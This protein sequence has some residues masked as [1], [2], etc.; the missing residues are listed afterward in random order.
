MGRAADPLDSIAQVMKSAAT[1]RLLAMV[2]IAMAA[3]GTSRAETPVG[4]ARLRAFDPA[5]LETGDLIRYRDIERRDFRAQDPPVEAIG[6]HAELGAATCVFLA[7]D[8]DM[9]IRS[10]PRGLDLGF[11]QFR[12]R[13]QN[14]GFIAYMDR[15]CSWW[16]PSP[17]MLPAAYILQHEQIHFALFEI[18]ARRLN[19]RA[20]E[21]T[22]QLETVTASQ[23]EAVDAISEQLDAELLRAVNEVVARSND[24]DR[25]TSLTYRQ[26]K[27]SFWW[28]TVSVELERYRRSRR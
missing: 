3:T 10:S 13:V 12:T 28:N 11:D 9:Y 16:N 2:F 17:M 20:L 21:L 27:Q 4:Q 5:L 24:F 23:Q 7:T 19:S 14:L 6:L 15:E 1:I 26:D 22:A 18:A 8:P 25:D